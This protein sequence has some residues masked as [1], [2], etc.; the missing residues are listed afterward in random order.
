[1]KY[2]IVIA[3]ETNR[4]LT[5]DEQNLIA[6]ACL[7]QAEEPVDAEGNQIDVDCTATVNV[8]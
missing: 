5:E 4:P 1:M 2:V 3:L 6:G 7:V 8:I